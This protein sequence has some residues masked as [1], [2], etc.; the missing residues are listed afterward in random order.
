MRNSG[1][2]FLAS[3]L[4]LLSLRVQHFVG[5][6]SCSPAHLQQAFC[7]ADIVIR[8]KISGKKLI[9]ENNGESF[10]VYNDLIRY[11]VKQIKMFK[12]FERKKT[13]QFV[14]TAP[15]SAAC[16]VT[17]N[18][19]SKVQYLLTGHLGSDGRVQ[20]GL[21]NYIL[22]WEELTLSQ[23]K[24]LNHR[25]QMGCDCRIST[26]YTLPCS[27][28]AENDCLWTDRLT[29]KTLNGP[30]AKYFSCIKRSDGSC[31]WYRGGSPPEKEFMD[32]SE[33]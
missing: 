24:N 15:T 7:S 9:S 31:S 22:P 5:G 4:L 14:Y 13:V 18:T 33:P 21:C 25:Y 23:R 12:G 10:D 1:T 11:E 2:R 27:V 32:I 16:G 30:Q 3:S 6:C 8:A 19:T 29:D 28:S 17:L 26:C 20:V